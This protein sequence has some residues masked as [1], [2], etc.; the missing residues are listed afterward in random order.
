MSA[1]EIPFEE[2][3][4]TKKVLY[5]NRVHYVTNVFLN[6]L[7]VISPKGEDKTFHVKHLELQEVKS[8]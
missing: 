8:K 7:C 2:L 5:R 1:V 3:F 4:V 6:G